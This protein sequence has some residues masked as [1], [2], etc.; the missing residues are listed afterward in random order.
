MLWIRSSRYPLLILFSMWFAVSSVG[1][2]WW[3]ISITKSQNNLGCDEPLEVRKSTSCSKQ[4]WPRRYTRLWFNCDDI[5]IA[6]TIYNTQTWWFIIWSGS[7]EWRDKWTK[8]MGVSVVGVWMAM[9]PSLPRD[10]L[11]HCSAMS[12]VR[13]SVCAG[14]LQLRGTFGTIACITC[15]SLDN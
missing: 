3:K 9:W 5:Y 1:G 11:S 14:G 6:I 13:A 15:V 10:A 4:G 12:G 2:L 8:Q 7:L